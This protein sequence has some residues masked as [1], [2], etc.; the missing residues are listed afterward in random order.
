MSDRAATRSKSEQRNI[1]F[2]QGERCFGFFQFGT[3]Q[4]GGSGECENNCARYTRKPAR[5][6]IPSLN[7]MTVGFLC[8]I[9]RYACQIFIGRI[10]RIA[11]SYQILRA[12]SFSGAAHVGLDEHAALILV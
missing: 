8:R 4:Q 2:L 1:H 9:S 11:T 10:A 12:I 6:R 3:S 7:I 5:G